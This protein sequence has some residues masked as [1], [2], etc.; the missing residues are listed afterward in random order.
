MRIGQV[1]VNKAVHAGLGSGELR[2]GRFVPVRG[3]QK[4]LVVVVV[5]VRAR[6]V[7]MLI[8]GVRP[9]MVVVVQTVEAV[10]RAAAARPV[11]LRIVI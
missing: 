6:V 2:G 9:S 1:E 8:V 5:K 7:R 4:V 11:L 10:E 3:Q